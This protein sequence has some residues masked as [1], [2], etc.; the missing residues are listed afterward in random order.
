MSTLEAEYKS[1]A[2]IERLR[3]SVFDLA[4][5]TSQ[6]KSFITTNDERV[7]ETDDMVEEVECVLL[8]TE[9][10]IPDGVF[11]VLLKPRLELP[12]LFLLILIRPKLLDIW[13]DAGESFFDTITQK[14]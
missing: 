14:E 13:T 2:A 10:I 11:Q 12:Q 9:P 3:T 5:G 6:A 4:I 7:R 8:S 1:G